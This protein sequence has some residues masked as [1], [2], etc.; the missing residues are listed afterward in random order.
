[1]VGNG[2]PVNV[3]Y[4]ETGTA[5]PVVQM[6]SATTCHHRGSKMTLRWMARARITPSGVPTVFVNKSVVE[7]MWWAARTE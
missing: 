7:E 6:R 3:G 2:E 4:F 1:M 5:R